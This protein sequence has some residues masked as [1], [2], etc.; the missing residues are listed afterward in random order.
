MNGLA[1]NSSLDQKIFS[2]H[3]GNDFD[4]ENTYIDFGLPD[5]ASMSDPAEL[6]YIDSMDD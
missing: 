1:E 5:V 2:V 4:D 3:L 6:V